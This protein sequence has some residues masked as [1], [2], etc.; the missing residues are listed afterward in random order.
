MSWSKIISS[1][2]DGT[3]RIWDLEAPIHKVTKH[4]NTF[5]NWFKKKPLYSDNQVLVTAPS[6]TATDFKKDKKR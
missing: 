5:I 1:S 6:K 4:A 3:V 2:E